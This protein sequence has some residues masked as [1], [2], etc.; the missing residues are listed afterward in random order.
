MKNVLV[1]LL[2]SALSYIQSAQTFA[3]LPSQRI[4]IA[5]RRRE[6]CNS[7]P[8]V[9]VDHETGLV[10]VIKTRALG[11]DG[12]AVINLRPRHAR[13]PQNVLADHIDYFSL[14]APSMTQPITVNS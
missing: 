1:P 14:E 11:N 4:W 5:S 3:G 6:F 8:E 7:N 2:T 10:L 13:S 9:G 12:E